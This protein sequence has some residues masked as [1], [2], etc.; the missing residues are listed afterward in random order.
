MNIQDKKVIKEFLTH[1]NYNVM[2]ESTSN[3]LESYFLVVP[4]EDINNP[5]LKDVFDLYVKKFPVINISKAT[6]DYIEEHKEILYFIFLDSIAHTD[7]LFEERS[8][9]VK[10]NFKNILSYKIIGEAV[11]ISEHLENHIDIYLGKLKYV[12]SNTS[13]AAKEVAIR[14]IQEG[15]QKLNTIWNKIK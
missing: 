2:H 12:S 10:E 5:L 11:N 4:K 6:K 15:K 1:F 13:I 7:S 8:L 3:F 9:F 14:K